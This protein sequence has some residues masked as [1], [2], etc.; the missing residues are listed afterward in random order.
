MEIDGSI[1]KPISLTRLFQSSVLADKILSGK[2]IATELT[3]EINK[4]FG[5]A[6]PFDL[7]GAEASP[8]TLVACSK[9]HERHNW[10][11][12]KANIGY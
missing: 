11:R 9:A 8:R 3:N 7:S 4:A 2:Q 1:S 6:P 10:C 12:Y 5:D